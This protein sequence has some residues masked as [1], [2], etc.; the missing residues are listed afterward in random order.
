MNFSRFG[1]M[2]KGAV[3][4]IKINKDMSRM[5]CAGDDEN[6]LLLFYS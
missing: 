5:A 2:S 1:A 3:R 6:G 4:C